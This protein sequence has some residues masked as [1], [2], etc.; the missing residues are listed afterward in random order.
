[1]L[2][3]QPGHDLGMA[4]IERQYSYEILSEQEIEN[5]ARVLVDR[6]VEQLFVSPT[7]AS[8]MLRYFRYVRYRCIRERDSNASF[9]WD[10]Q[11]LVDEWLDDSDKVRERAGVSEGTATFG[12]ALV[13]F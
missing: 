5:R 3:P 6:I 8:M 2:Q 7:E 9:R 11:K 13:L 12:F 4:R 10:V 1:M